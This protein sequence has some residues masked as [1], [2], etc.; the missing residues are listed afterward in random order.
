MNQIAIKTDT[1]EKIKFEEPSNYDVIFLNDDA[2][3]YDFVIMVLKQV[4]RK[5]D[6]QAI[7]LTKQIHE[8]GSGIVGTYIWEIAEQKSI[9]TTV[10]AR[11][12][13]HP[14]QIKVQKSKS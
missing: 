2:T 3:T 12:Q 7:G 11:E 14:L 13:G 1:K 9:E 10:L 8:K 6:D 5:S 4:F